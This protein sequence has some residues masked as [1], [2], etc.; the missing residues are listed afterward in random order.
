MRQPMR[1]LSQYVLEQWK[2]NS[3][4]FEL[5]K[6]GTFSIFR[7]LNELWGKHLQLLLQKLPLALRRSRR[8]G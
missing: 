1:H 2:L 7:M 3:R 5:F 6:Q 8:E 4:F